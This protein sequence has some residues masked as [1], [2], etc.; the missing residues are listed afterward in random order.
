MIHLLFITYF[1]YVK[2]MRQMTLTL[3]ILLLL[4]AMSCVPRD[5]PGEVSGSIGRPND[6]RLAGGVQLQSSDG[7]IVLEPD[8]AWGTQQLVQLLE[9]AA[10][11]MRE[12]YPETVP[13]VV[14]HLSSR[15]GGRLSPHSSHQ[16]GRDVDVAMYSKRNRLVRGFVNMGKKNLDIEKTWFFME[17][18]LETGFIQYILLDWSVQK[19]IYEEVKIAVPRQRLK[20]Y[21]QYPRSRGVR[22]GIIRHATGHRN[23]L[24][25]RIFCPSTDRYCED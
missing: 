7:I 3:M 22:E 1:R 12:A 16:S 13:L 21:F 4:V 9:M 5:L 11:E 20:T 17:T 18:L 15:R 23:H 6:G 2:R 19:I 25:I 14:G 24:H 10:L 8:K